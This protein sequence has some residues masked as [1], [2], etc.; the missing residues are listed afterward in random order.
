MTTLSVSYG[1]E[2]YEKFV[3]PYD[4]ITF[5][6]GTKTPTLNLNKILGIIFGTIDAE[7][8]K[9]NGNYSS[10]YPLIKQYLE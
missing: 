1:Q 10:I 5:P 2:S 9:D 7:H 8:F 4:Y 6:M 3:N